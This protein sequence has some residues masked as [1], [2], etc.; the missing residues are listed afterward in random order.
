MKGIICSIK[1]GFPGSFN[2]QKVLNLSKCIWRPYSLLADGGYR[3][4]E[5]MQ[6]LGA[7]FTPQAV[8][9]D[10]KY[11]QKAER[12]LIEIVIG[13]IKRFQCLRSTWYHDTVLLKYIMYCC[14]AI[15]NRNLKKK[16]IRKEPT[17]FSQ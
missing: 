15:A 2:D 12:V 4:S 17:N 16:P 10:V 9:G 6:T 3:F 8:S 14:A 5:V 13:F 11:V 7:I 1:T